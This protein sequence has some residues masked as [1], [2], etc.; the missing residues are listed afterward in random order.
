MSNE[1]YNDEYEL[2][3]EINLS[4]S[5]PSG[6]SG[7]LSPAGRTFAMV[8]GVVAIL[9]A[10]VYCAWAVWVVPTVRGKDVGFNIINS[11]VSEFTFDVAKPQD[12]SVLCSID[13]LNQSYAQVGTRDVLIGPAEQFEQR[14][15]VEVRT[16]ER[17]VS[18]TVNQCV[19]VEED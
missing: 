18:V 12:R 17:P 4:P 19:L 7:T 1:Y 2:E 6:K 13:A 10:V 5:T 11:E 14:F 15:T 8:V 3:E 9:A 16:S